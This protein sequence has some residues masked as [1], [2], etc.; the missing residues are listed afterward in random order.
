MISVMIL[1]VTHRKVN[2]S[3]MRD[4]IAGLT[5]YKLYISLEGKKILYEGTTYVKESQHQVF[6]KW[7]VTHGLLKIW[8][9]L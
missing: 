3:Q 6:Y 2:K 8:D 7:H 5:H 4:S 1:F 9:S